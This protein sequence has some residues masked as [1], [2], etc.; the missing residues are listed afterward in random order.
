MQR[1]PSLEL[2][3]R[4]VLQ[5]PLGFRIHAEIEVAAGDVGAEGGHGTR[6]LFQALVDV[7][8]LLVVAQ[9]KSTV[10]YPDLAVLVG[11]GGVVEL[12]QGEGAGVVAPNEELLEGRYVTAGGGFSRAL[13]RGW[14]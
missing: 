5:H 14:L 1:Q 12:E 9:V 13:A 10:G 3:G 2:A 6:G 8:R 4:G 7:G 11:L